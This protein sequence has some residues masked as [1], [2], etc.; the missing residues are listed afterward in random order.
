[1]SHLIFSHFELVAIILAVLVARIL[2]FDGSSNWLK[3][4]MLVALTSCSGLDSSTRQGWPPVS[5]HH[6][7][8]S[9]RRRVSIEERPPPLLIA[10]VMNRGGAHE[11]VP[12]GL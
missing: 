5:H 9:V 1:M 8:R 11:F 6:D 12:S 2:I 10:L 7:S 3:G 4:L